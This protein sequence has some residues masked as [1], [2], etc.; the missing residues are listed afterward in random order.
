MGFTFG[1]RTAVNQA[2][3]VLGGDR[4]AHAGVYGWHDSGC[5]DGPREFA[6]IYGGCCEGSA[7]QDTLHYFRLDTIRSV[8]RG[9]SRTAHQFIFTWTTLNE[10]LQVA[11]ADCS[12]F[13]IYA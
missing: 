12:H 13:A 5:S 11:K 9:Q 10:V 1:T 4:P 8:L 6:R 3:S 2:H 7:M